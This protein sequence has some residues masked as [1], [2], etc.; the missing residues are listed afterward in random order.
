M[1][2]NIMRFLICIIAIPILYVAVTSRM[3][4]P[5]T[6]GTLMQV[7]FGFVLGFLSYFAVRKRDE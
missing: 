4:S 7:D 3:F 6:N 5:D 2:D 1:M